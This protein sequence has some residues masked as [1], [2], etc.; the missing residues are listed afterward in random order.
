[1]NLEFK[2]LGFLKGSIKGSIDAV[3]EDEEE[4]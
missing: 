3:F 2:L 4:K 1:V